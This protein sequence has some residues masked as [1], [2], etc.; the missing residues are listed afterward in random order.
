MNLK[1]ALLPGDGIGPEVTAQAVKCLQAVEE[2]FGHRF[3]FTEAAVGAVAIERT[4]DPLPPETL[5]LCRQSDAIL[6]GAIGDPI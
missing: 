1:I 5:K 4:G 3:R 6:F 2:T